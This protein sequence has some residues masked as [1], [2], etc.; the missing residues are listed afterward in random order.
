MKNLRLLFPA[1]LA[2]LTISAAQAQSQSQLSGVLLNAGQ[3]NPVDMMKYSR[4]N[5]SFTTARAAAMGGAFTALGGDMASMSIN[6]AGLGMYRNSV[7]GLSPSLTI[8]DNRNTY[9]AYDND[10]TKFSFNNVGTVL[11]FYQGSRGLISFNMGF[12]YNKLE[13]FN[14]SGGVRMPAGA[15]GSILN[16]LQLQLNGLYDYMNTG[17]WNGLAESDL[18]RDPYNNPDIYVNEWGGV[19]GYELGIFNATGN[20]MY[21]LNGLPESGTLTPSLRY[22]SRGSVGE[23]NIAGGF[24]IG[25]ILYLG[26]DFGFQDIYQNMALS[27]TENYDENYAG[28]SQQ[29]LKQMRYNQY[30]Y[31][32]G[33]AFNFKLGAIIRPI[34]ALRLGIS[35]HSPSYTTLHKEYNAGMGTTRFGS[36]MENYKNTLVTGWDYEYNSPSRLLLGAAV[37][38]GDY[39]ALSFDYE[40]VWFNK[41]SYES[42]TY[43]VRENFRQSIARDY[44]PANNFRVGLEVKPISNLALRLGYATYGSPIKEN[45]ENGSA[46]IFSNIFTTSSHHITAG[47]GVWLNRATTLDIAYIYSQ[48]K[49]APYDLYYYDGPARLPSGNQ[50]EVTYKPASEVTGGTLNR[51]TLTMSFNFFF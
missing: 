30:V 40:R 25:N 38:L 50:T 3:F 46:K 26:F 8:S 37:T 15:G 2:T 45:F 29:Y 17:N 31:A 27:Y 19:L 49:V 6:P 28:P 22:D 51:H 9:A 20:N 44:Q 41:M 43:E 1:L 42:E 47:V 23:Y 12:S 36:N 39:V 48:Y 24:N 32:Q 34:P 16:I 4:N 14:F 35:Y 21:A 5:Y 11:N 7:W 10:K 18:R 13:D 33:S